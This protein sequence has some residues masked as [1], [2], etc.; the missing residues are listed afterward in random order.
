MSPSEKKYRDTMLKKVISTKIINPGE[1]ITK[2]KIC[3]QRA[4]SYDYIHSSKIIS[5]I[6][7]NQKLV[8]KKIIGFGE[9]LSESQF[10]IK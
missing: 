7:S 4:N 2:D 5:L 9:I 10:E 1:L 8:A 3:F 6:D